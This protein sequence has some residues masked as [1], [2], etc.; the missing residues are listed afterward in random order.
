M[1][2]PSDD[3]WLA[4]MLLSALLIFSLGAAFVALI[5]WLIL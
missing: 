2:W 1:M 4:G 5:W 3:T